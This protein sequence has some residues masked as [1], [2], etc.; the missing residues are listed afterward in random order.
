MTC[1]LRQSKSKFFQRES[2]NKIFKKMFSDSNYK[3]RLAL[4]KS[5]DSIDAKLGFVRYTGIQEKKG[6]LINIQPSELVDE[7]TKIIVSVVDYFFISDMDER[8]KISYPFRPYFYIATLDGFEFQVSSYLSKKYGAQTAVEHMDKEDLDLKDHLSGIK[9]TYI[10]LSFASTV[11]LMKVRKDLMPLVRKNTDRIKKESAYA[12]YLAKNLGGKGCG[13]SGSV[14]LIDGDI[15]NQIVDIREYD[16]P[17]HMRVSIDEKIF[18]G[19]WY[20]VKGVGPNRVPTIKRKDLAF[21]HAK[22]KVLA[23][24]IETTKLPLKFPDRESD[25]IMMIS[26]MVDGRGFLIIN[27][28][29]VSADINA[30]EYTPK[31]EYK[32]EFTVWNEKDETAL[33][34]KFFD[35]FLQVRPNIVVTYN[36]D[37]FDWPFVEAR[38]KIRGF[39]MEREIGFSKDSADEYKS[40]NC[41]HMDAFR[42]VKRD[43][44]LPVGSQNLKAVTKAKL[45]Y[46]PVEVEPELMCKMAREQPQQL[47]NYSVSDAVS[48]YYLYMKYVHQFIFALCTIIPLGADDVLRKG[49]GTLC[50]ALLM[51]EAF[52][53]NIVFPNKYTGPEETKFSKEGHRVESETYVGGHVEALEAGVFRADIPARFRLAVP[54]LEQLKSEAKETLRKELAREFE[55]TLDQVIDFEEQC[56]EVE[57]AFNGLIEVPTRLENPRIYHLDVG[58]MYP[59]IILTN[60]LQPCAMV[61]EEI[62]MGCSFNKPDAECKRTMAWEWRG[63]LLPASRGEY[64]QIMQ[65]L[66]AES[67]GKP[68]KHFHMLERSE[69]EAIEMKRVKDYC[70]RVYGKTHLTKNEMRETTICQRE[71][72]FYV[73]T[74]KAF[75]DRR[76]EYKDMLKKAKGRFDQAQASNDLATVATAKLEMVL[77]ESLQL[78]HKCI[79]NSFYGYVMR[80]GSRWYSME[81]AGIVCHTGANIIKEATKLV[82]QIGKPLE[83]DTD[84]IW[85]LIPASFPENVTFK[86]KNHKRNSVTVSYPGRLKTSRNK[87]IF[88]FPGAMLNA[89]V[90]EG[91]TNHQYHTLEKDGSYLKSSENSIYFEVDGPYQC[92]VLPASK[93]EGKKLKKRYAVFNLD[94]SMAEMKGFELKRRGE[95]NIIKHFQSHVFKTFL[96]GKTLE[97]TYKAVAGDANHWLDILHTHG[98][99]ITDDELFD[100]I[101]ENRSMSRKLEEYGSQKSTSISTAK[102]LAEF[103]GDDM[104]KDA[105]LACMFIISR[106]PIGSPVTDRAI[107]VAIFKAEPKVRS[108][109]I[110]KWTKQSDFDEDTDIRDMLDWDYYIERFGSCIQKIITIPAAYQGVVNPVPRVPHPDWLQNKI[111]NKIDAHKQPR[112]NQIFAACQKPTTTLENGKRRRTPSCDND[113]SDDVVAIE[114]S[115]FQNE[116]DKENGAKRQKS[117]VSKNPKP[118]EA[119]APLEKKTLIDHGFDEWMGFLKKKWRIQRKE[120]KTLLKSRDSDTV[121]SIVRGTREAESEREWHI[122]SVEPTADTSFFNVWLSVQGQ[123]QKV[124]MKIGRKILVDSRAP[125]G[126][127]ETV[128]RTLPHH[129][130]PGFLYEFKTD[131]AQLTALM[132]KLYSETCSSTIDGIYE[133]EVPTEFRAVL[134]LGSTVR[135]DHGVSLGHQLTLDCL[136]PM[137]KMSYLSNEQNIRTIFLYKFSQDSRHVYSL[138]D[139]SGSAAYFYIVNSGDVQLPNMDAL[140]TSAYNKMMSTERGQLCKTPEKISFTVKRFSSSQ[141]CERQVGRALRAFREFSSKTT[142]CL[143]LSDTEPSRLAR[144]IPNLGLFPNVR[145]HLTEPSSLLNQIDW[146]KVVARRVLQHYFNSFFFLTDYLE[147]AKYLRVPIGN[148]PADHALFG[149]DLLYARHLQ[150]T[151][152]ALW[153]TKA[154]RPDLGGKELDDIRLSIDWNPLSVDDTVLLNREVFSDTACVELQLSA[155]A[156][157]AL[158]QRSR[159]LEAEGADDVV[160]FDSMNT[161]AQQS[162]TGGTVN[163][164]ACYDEGAAVDASIKIL[165]QMLTEC[166]RHIAHQGNRHADEVVMTVSR[167]LNTRSALLF[168]SALTRS[169]SVL[170][171]KLVL[172]L[173]AECERIGAKV[174][175]ATA[176]KLVLNTGKLTSEEAKGFVEMLIQSLST[177]VVFAALHIT[178][179][180]FFDAMLWMDAHNHTGIRISQNDEP[181]S[182]DIIDDSEP[183]ESSDEPQYE[184][185]AIWKIAEEMPDESNIREEFLQMIGAYILEFLETNREMQFDSES[186][187]TFRADTISQKISHRLYRVVNKLVH[188]SAAESAHC[189]TYLVDS[190]CRALSCDQTSQLAVEGVRENAKRL[191]HN[192]V[193]EVDMTPLRSTTLFVSNVFCNSCSQASNVFLSSTNEI[194][195]CHTCQSK[196]NSDVIDMMICDRLNQLLTAYQ[197]QDHQCSKCKSVSSAPFVHLHANP[198]SLQVRHDSLS[199]YCECCSPFVP[200]IT[201]S[202]LKHEA[203]TVETVANVRNF[204]L[205]SELATWILKML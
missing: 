82:D 30:F 102:R 140:Y 63:E 161:I 133:S 2:S 38:A 54:A 33:I 55:V 100:L 59:N 202:Q 84:G 153:A 118:K 13:A 186:A 56:S 149:L 110:R 200:Q 107:P 48:T 134:Q 89:L 163:A 172:L 151:G 79:L 160:T 35:H 67:F 60:R 72:H 70:R 175:H 182:A 135:P 76:Y 6:F 98:A 116:E 73:E 189:A 166:V 164:I 1:L 80:K 169:I 20:D 87:L 21:F 179:V 77:Y 120:R 106:H 66:E 197:I 29:I 88:F 191:L 8:F 62:C 155:V 162:I 194:L 91:F 198:L 96:V 41:I 181:E 123:L 34:R 201:P 174:I 17:F 65:Q 178:P 7:Q 74:V 85:C 119:E 150:K 11:E 205:S 193:V 122:L 32:G 183:A 129:K 165:K 117:A 5:N 94:G 159:V 108:H 127:R 125:R 75:R 139:T 81:M 131:E 47:A 111:R 45:R 130:P 190:L 27:R 19:L 173:C 23:F 145:L 24:D 18:V 9:K 83:L 115:D 90:Y 138:I 14:D 187:A 180:K 199:L 152:H 99:D 97:E 40:R 3:E 69:R 137:E 113:D 22:P 26:Y 203:A 16:V 132:D 50:E 146:Q 192:V 57:E 184:T 4:I 86:L 112:I 51:V 44:Y 71:N 95:L 31:A 128:R 46:D 49:S 147:W 12:D 158:V 148:L 10:K 124:T 37:F 103:L 61:N 157:T 156:V 141:E 144:K 195:T 43:S 39:N 177:N 104:V 121:E 143:S 114:G 101:S 196:L 92:M 176:Q 25:E 142:V 168:D 15:L 170:E 109:Y 93:E 105:G 42:W 36:G 68:P 185:T 64:Q 53:N 204:A 52:H 167:W 154:S 126:N 58:A 171:S 136:R 188:S 78:A 28:E